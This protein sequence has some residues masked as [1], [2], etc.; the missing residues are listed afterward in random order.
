ML[1]AWIYIDRSLEIQANPNMNTLANLTHY[2][3]LFQDGTVSQTPAGPAMARGQ[4]TPVNTLPY[5]IYRPQ[6]WGGD[7][8]YPNY[9]NQTTLNAPPLPLRPGT[10]LTHLVVRISLWWFCRVTVQTIR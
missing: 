5:Q 10:C 1:T 6:E 3:C 8:M 7:R 9:H 4:W 2:M